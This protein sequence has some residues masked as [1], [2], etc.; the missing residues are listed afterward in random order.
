LGHHLVSCILFLAC[1]PSESYLAPPK[2]PTT[3]I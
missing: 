2:L 3:F 1:L